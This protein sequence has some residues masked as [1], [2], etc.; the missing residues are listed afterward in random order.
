MDPDRRQTRRRSASGGRSLVRHERRRRIGRSQQ[1]LLTVIN[2]VLNFARLDSGRVALAPRALALSEVMHDAAHLATPLFGTRGVTFDVRMVTESIT[3]HADPDRLQ[4]ILLN[5]LSNAAKFTPAGGRVA[6]EHESL[7]DA[8]R[9]HVTDT[10]VGIPAAKLQSV[11]EPF[12]QLGRSLSNTLEGTGFGLA[13]SRELARAMGGDLTARSRVRE[14][15]TFTVTMP[16]GGAAD[17]V[18][19]ADAR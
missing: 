10:G 4:Q 16:R 19:T 9:L 13:I 18:S 3:I 12:V 8:V 11:F 1:H 17:T 5:L 15:S 2:D 14:G 6:L 7:A